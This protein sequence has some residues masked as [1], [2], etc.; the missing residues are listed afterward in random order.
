MHITDEET[1]AFFEGAILRSEIL[2]VYKPGVGEAY[3][4]LTA[5]D[6]R[7]YIGAVTGD[8]NGWT[9]WI[10]AEKKSFRVKNFTSAVQLIELSHDASW[11]EGAS[12]LSSR[13][14][15]QK[16]DEHDR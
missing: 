13:A 10:R 6:K 12:G 5:D 7:T 1:Q 8:R 16:V 2:Q 11:K 3:A 15:I 14:R 9:A 4:I